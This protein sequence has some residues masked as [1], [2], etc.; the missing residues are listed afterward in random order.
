M[1]YES[2][3]ESF[4]VLE[5]PAMT[6]GGR[7]QLVHLGQRPIG[8]GVALEVSPGVRQRVQLWSVRGEPLGDPLRCVFQ[9]ALDELGAVALPAIPAHDDPLPQLASEQGQARSDQLGIEVDAGMQ[10]E[11]E[12]EAVPCGGHAEG[13][14]DRGFPD[15]THLRRDHRRLA[16][17]GPAAPQP[18][19]QEEARLVEEGQPGLQPR[20]VFLTRGHASSFHRWM[21]ASSRAMARR[22]GRWGVQ[23]NPRS[24]RLRWS[25]W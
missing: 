23:P 10:P 9:P 11:V 13:G 19:G 4:I 7:G 20:G 5:A 22:W 16:L 14:D 21:A 12:P 18:G 17:G 1:S 2:V 15:P 3:E 24:S 6:A 25:T 8:Q